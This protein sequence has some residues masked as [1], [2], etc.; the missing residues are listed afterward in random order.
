MFEID[1]RVLVGDEVKWIAAL[2]QGD[3]E[4]NYHRT[5]FGIFLDVTGRKQA[6]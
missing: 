4:S 5:M 2:G 1:F 3:D 6:G